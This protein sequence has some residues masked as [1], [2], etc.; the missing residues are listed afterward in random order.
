MKELFGIVI[1]LL[2][3]Y[4]YNLKHP[5]EEIKKPVS[6]KEIL[7][8]KIINKENNGISNG[9]GNYKINFNELQKEEHNKL[10]KF[11]LKIQLYYYYNEEAYEEMVTEIENFLVLFRAINIDYSYGGKFYDLMQDKKSLILNNLRSIGIK[12]PKQYNLNEALNDLEKILDEYLEKAY[13]L[14]KN[15]IH[16]NGYNYTVKMINPKELAHNRF[17]EDISSFSYY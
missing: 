5:T 17:S 13:Y 2:L 16:K 9:N 15:Y 10:S 3:F 6:Y 7:L 14:Y 12:L 4:Y 11:L 1:L 8:P